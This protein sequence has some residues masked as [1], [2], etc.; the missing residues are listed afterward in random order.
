M[1]I[2]GE[3]LIEFLFH[4]CC[5]WLGH[6]V[7]RILTLGKIKMEYGDETPS[8]LAEVVGVAFLI[9]VSILIWAIV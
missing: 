7:V 4:T 1:S 3:I 9:P 5:G 2:I 8:C 6:W